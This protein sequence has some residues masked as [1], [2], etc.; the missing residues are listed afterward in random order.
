MCGTARDDVALLAP[1]L[2]GGC[3]QALAAA[4]ASPDPHTRAAAAGH[5]LTHPAWRRR[6]RSDSDAIVR[7]APPAA[8]AC[9]QMA[10][11]PYPRVRAVAAACESCPP[12]VL[13]A[14]VADRDEEVRRAAASN[15]HT[16]MSALRKRIAR[17]DKVVALAA[18][19]NPATPADILV[20]LSANADPKIRAAAA[21]HPATPID[22]LV[23]LSASAD[24]KTRAA[25]AA[26]PA[27]PPE[28]L[29]GLAVGSDYWVLAEI[30]GNPRTPASALRRLGIDG[31][32]LDR[33]A[34][35]PN[36][37]AEILEG[38]A[39]RSCMHDV[40]CD[41]DGCQWEGVDRAD[42]VAGILVNPSTPPTLLE[43]LYKHNIDSYEMPFAVVR[44][45]TDPEM[46]A[47]WA[48]H[49]LMDVRC[50][51]ASN[52]HLS[53]ATLA[54]LAS[55]EDNG[56]EIYE[57]V[58]RHPNCPPSSLTELLQKGVSADL[59]AA[60]PNCPPDILEGFASGG[61]HLLA[62]ASNP[63]CPPPVLDALSAHSD[64]AARARVAANPAS[65]PQSLA[66]LSSDTDEQVLVALAARAAS[67]RL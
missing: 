3:V 30:A 40:R 13:A 43:S 25:V 45:E 2:R 67:T 65:W 53:A 7:W 62:V 32:E 58:A 24:I 23:E 17:R 26:H 18:A 19:G 42:V 16:P 1:M 59:I 54:V 52:P 56:H 9:E 55:E 48:S 36:C 37:P 49:D 47:E 44:V 66:V 29:E 51:L 46:L 41:G 21:A 35:N 38:I 10:K 33:L 57:T 20:R 11:E 15:E 6:L 34:A 5:R 50:D 39:L 60:N 22:I 61:Q 31:L 64:P 14:F 63:S 8:E 12:R 28:I 27:T 4:A